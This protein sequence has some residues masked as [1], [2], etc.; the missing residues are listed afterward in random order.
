MP[1]APPVCDREGMDWYLRE[2]RALVR[3]LRQ[4]GPD[5]PTLCEGWRSRHL[6][7]HLYLRLHRPWHMAPGAAVVGYDADE[8]TVRMGDRAAGPEEYLRL[9]EAFQAP[10]ARSNP[11]GWGGNRMHL[12][13]YVVHHED[14]RRA[15]GPY[16]P[17]QLPPPQRRAL[18]E[19]VR[20]MG[21]LTQ[22]RAPHGVVLVVPEGPR[23]V[24]KRR[25]HAVAV[26]GTEVEL[27]LWLTGRTEHAD[28]RLTATGAPTQPPQQSSAPAP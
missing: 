23:A 25:A 22:A 7:A 28:V 18:W 12:L 16:Q 21:R 4:V 19:Q 14:V 8:V 3:T 5:A 20:L 10:P 2:Q 13:E 9:L 24:V 6:A 26:T 27:A 17:R 11:V 15:G 1:T